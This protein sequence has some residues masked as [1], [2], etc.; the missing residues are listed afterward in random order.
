MTRP[1]FSLSQKAMIAFA[2]VLLPILVIFLISYLSSKR[3]LERV[4]L[5]DL[6][7]HADDRGNDVVRFV[8]LNKQ[9]AT[10]FAS[11]GHIVAGLRAMQAAG[12][13]DDGR[14]SA[15]IRNNK[16][17]LDKKIIRVVL[18]A[19]KKMVASTDPL[20]RHAE[21]DGIEAAALGRAGV[22]VIKNGPSGGPELAFMVSIGGVD[23]AK[24]IG[25]LITF[26]RLSELER[27]ITRTAWPEYGEA[28]SEMTQSF[29]TLDIYLVDTEGM[30]ITE[31]KYIKDGVFKRRIDNGLIDTCREKRER[32]SGFYADYRGIKV[33]GASLCMPALGFTLIVEIDS[34]EAL[35]PILDNRRYAAVSIV[36]TIGLLA[37][38]YLYFF[39]R[40]IVQITEVTNAAKEVAAGNYSVRL[41]VRTSDEIGALTRAFGGMA[42]D[43]QTRQKE[44]KES[45]VRLLNAQRIAHFGSFEYKPFT[46]EMTWSEELYR[47]LGVAPGLIVPSHKSLTSFIHI[48]SRPVAQDAFEN[49]C[50][51]GKPYAHTLKVVRLDGAERTVRVQCESDID[52]AGAVVKVSGIIHD[53]TEQARLEELQARLTAIIE[54]TPDFVATGD[55]NGRVLYYNKAARKILGIADNEDVSDIRILDTHPAWAAEKVMNEGLPTAAREGSWSGETA[56]LSRDKHEIPASQVIIAHKD[57]EGK[58]EFYSTVA[59]DI[60]ERKRAERE[61]MEMNAALEGRVAAR[62]KQLLEANK[63][64]EAFSYSVAH[65]LRGPLR[66][67]DGF[68][69]ALQEDM[70]G[71]LD[72]V[73]LDHIRRVRGAASRMSQLI[74][75]LLGLSRITIVEMSHDLVNL[76]AIAGGIAADLKKTGPERNCEF[77]I[78]KGLVVTGDVRLLRVAMENLFANAWKFTAKRDGARIEFGSSGTREGRRVYYVKDNGAGFDMKYADKLFGAFQRLHPAA[79]FEGTGVGLATVARGIKRHGGTVWAEG[80]VGG[81]AIFYFTL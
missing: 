2:V 16:M 64:L 23:A 17:S 46:N 20:Y 35:K 59:R 6:R 39:R 68:S 66:I 24:K 54:A 4:V 67:I 10:D 27:V 41:P 50:L 40:L 29:E 9:R 45:S 51:N 49:A 53:I 44:L 1:V 65:D 55:T 81:G 5:K 14:L 26:L 22:S 28:V 7:V 21:H 76:S 33:A 8:E 78:E 37:A 71:R 48:D 63:E 25:V 19:D 75:D 60:T 47:I 31:A 12:R 80:D 18:I 70:E 34:N 62:T 58:I 42:D 56:F 52:G 36:I 3:E 69:H 30:L 13:I 72:P 15:Y 77:V 61:I 11:D 38:L 43:L 32:S 74:D 73:A 57:A 79:E